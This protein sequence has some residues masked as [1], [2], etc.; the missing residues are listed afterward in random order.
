MAVLALGCSPVLLATV[1]D[2]HNDVL[3][4]L[5]LLAV[6]LLVDDH[7]YALAGGGR[8]A[9]D[10]HQ[11]ARGGADRRGR[12]VAAVAT[13]L[14]SG[15]VVRRSDARRGHDRLPGGRRSRGAAAR[16]ARTPATT[17][18]S[19]SGSSCATAASSR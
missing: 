16:C 4:G 13:R 14:A 2:A 12:G 6:V 1:N 7:R 18:A 11:G 10:R 8:V 19:R 17:A 5:G 15:A 3:L 9:G